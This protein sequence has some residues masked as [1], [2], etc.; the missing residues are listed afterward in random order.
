MSVITKNLLKSLLIAPYDEGRRK[1]K[2]LSGYSSPTFVHHILY[3]LES[4]EIELIIGMIKHDPITIWEHKEYV[5]MADSTKRLNVKYYTGD[6]PIHSKL[7]YW[8]KDGFLNKPLA[9]VGSA[10]FTR[11][12]YINYQETM[13][14][15]EPGEALKAFPVDHLLDFRT[16]SIEEVINF[17]YQVGHTTRIDT[18]AVANVVR[19]SKPSVDLLLTTADN[20]RKIQTTAGLNWGQRPGREPNQAYIPVPKKIHNVNPN[21]FPET[22]VEFTL[23]TDDGE[24]FVCV[25]AQD[26]N[27]AIETC[28]DNSILGKYFRNRLGVPLGEFVTIEHLDNYGRNYVTM[29]K[30]NDETY[31]M[32]FS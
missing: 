14:R 19:N 30:I 6:K 5:K 12:G 20:P 28:H 31:F 32:D 10:N 25:M 18:S 13:A 27:K 15:A 7:I 17:D 24:S 21:F 22:K 29:Y 26:N 9:F 11:N 8:E 23:I 16:P 4:V 1:L 2:I 3:S